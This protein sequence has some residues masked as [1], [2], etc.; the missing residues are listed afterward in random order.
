MFYCPSKP[1]DKVFNDLLTIAE[2]GLALRAEEKRC[3]QES[4]V[5]G[6][7]SAD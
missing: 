3:E 6:K 5:N 1:V 7:L 2:S 4:E